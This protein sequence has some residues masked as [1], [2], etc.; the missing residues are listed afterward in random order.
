MK[1]VILDNI[2]FEPDIDLLTKKLRTRKGSSHSD[3]LKS[4][5][6]EA[7]TVAKPKA[8]Y[9]MAFI[10]SKGD[11]WVHIDGVKLTSRV[12]RVNLEQAHR[13][14]L[15]VATCGTELEDW[16]NGL[17][18]MLERFW[19]DEIKLMALRSVTAALNA[20]L[21]ERF[22]PGPVSRMSPGSLG[23][24]PLRE[25]RPLFELLGN[26]K[27]TIGVELSKRLLM[28]PT[29]SVSGIQFPT[30]DNFESC[31]LCP[32]EDCPGR[33]APHDDGLYDR[34]YRPQGESSYRVRPL[35]HDD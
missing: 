7:Q 30:A 20:H 9:R 28:M 13:V 23:D 16:S 29:K 24:W 11:D 2:P 6:R 27:E 22:R 3:R 18:D 5:A 34:K 31:Q 15:Y 25:Q 32:R 17:N 35:G 1:S 19:A 12:L 10:E 33:R 4:L 21:D 8:L 14:F 26:P